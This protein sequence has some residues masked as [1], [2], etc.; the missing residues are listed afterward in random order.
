[1]YSPTVTSAGHGGRT[2]FTLRAAVVKSAPEVA[3]ALAG[4]EEGWGQRLERLAGLT[5]RMVF[6]SGEERDRV[7]K[8]CGADEGATQTL[9]RLAEHLAEAS[10]QGA[11]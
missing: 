4:M 5:M 6:P 3:G 10:A 11:L 2:E 8:E 7:V 9:G 1:M